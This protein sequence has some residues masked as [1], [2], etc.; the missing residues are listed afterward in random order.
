[1]CRGKWAACSGSIETT[2]QSPEVAAKREIQEETTLTEADIT[3]LRRGKPFSVVDR[4]LKTEWTIYPFAW[5]MKDGA[6]DM[7]LDWEHTEYEFISPKDIVN[8]DAVPNLDFG[9]R[10]VL[11]GPETERSLNA[12]RNN[13]ESGAQGLALLALDMLLKAVRGNDLAHVD[14]TEDF[15]NELRMI[16]WHLAKNGRPSM[17]AAIEAALL[18]AL[19]TIRTYLGTA[20]PAGPEGIST[21]E[22]GDFK[23]IAES[24][25]KGRIATQMQRLEALAQSFAQFIMDEGVKTRS[26]TASSTTKIV[27]LSSS[28]TVAQCLMDLIWAFVSNGMNIKLCILESRPNFEGVAFANALLDELEKAKS[29][30]AYRGLEDLFRYLEIEIVSDASAAMIVKHAD[31]V[32][33]G[34]DKVLPNGHISNKIGSLMI[35]ATAKM[36]NSECKVVIAFETDKITGAS[37]S[38][39]NS[40]VEYNDKTEVTN[41]WPSSVT[42]ALMEKQA[43][44]FQVEVKNA[45]FEWVPS[46]YIDEYLTE[47]GPL[48][49]EDIRMLSV[50]S[51]ELE[52]RIFHDV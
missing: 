18:G 45:Y 39:E 36:L 23:D 24:A 46:S 28:G 29:A 9:L 17:G 21:L 33:L 5:M 35:A 27:T 10:R 52:K 4:G 47:K 25:I 48:T 8:Y 11:V 6:K 20:N 3:L 13:H 44:G 14:K 16:A 26:A 15:W 30:R 31:Y 34:A 32:V 1:M 38:T 49:M 43:K 22:L 2:D 50:E 37:D 41:V 42:A 51:N 7:K 40:K 12:L 19:D